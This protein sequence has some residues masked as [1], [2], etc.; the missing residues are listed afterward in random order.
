MATT[1]DLYVKTT[2]YDVT[3]KA[4]LRYYT[5]VCSTEV[6]FKVYIY[7]CKIVD[8]GFTNTSLQPNITQKIFYPV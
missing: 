8:G 4:C 2:G 3:L 5:G 1:N 7:E 6:S